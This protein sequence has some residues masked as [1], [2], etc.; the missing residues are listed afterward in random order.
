MSPINKAAAVE[1]WVDGAKAKSEKLVRKYTERTDKLARATSDDAQNAYVAGVTDPV[2][3]RLRLIRLKELSEEDLNRGM[4]EKG[5]TTYPAGIDAGK[6]K[7]D[8]RVGP[9]MDEIDRIVP[10]MEARTR[11][12]RANVMNRVIPIA[13]GLQNKKK[14]IVGR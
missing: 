2:S 13:T 1:D 8:R 4:R 11:D 3:Q 14:A 10:T 9:Y 5:P 12:A 6:E 7:Y